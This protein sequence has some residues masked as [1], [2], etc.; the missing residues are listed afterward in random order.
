MDIEASKDFIIE[1]LSR[2]LSP[3]LYY[4][5][6]EHTLD[7]HDSAVQI[8]KLE[9]VN[10]HDTLL[11]R[12][13]AYLHDTGLINTY[14]GHE[15]ASV[16]IAKEHL[17]KFGYT[18]DEI[19][20]IS[21]MILTTKLPQNAETKLEQILCDADLDY[22]GRDDFFM[23][24]HRLRYEWKKYAAGTTLKEWYEIQINFL[25]NHKYFT[26]SAR[27][28]RFDRKIYNLNQIKEVMG[29]LTPNK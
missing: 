7:V 9:D 18:P 23:I 14:Y 24:A 28:L 25:E 6:I 22:L 5:S 11:L 17:P 10:A 8:A 26:E 21:A 12:T 16:E 1:K 20:K 4:H 2:E 29:V 27:K 15:E 13:A 19:D 3:D